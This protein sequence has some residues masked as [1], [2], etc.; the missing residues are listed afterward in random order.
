MWLEALYF[1]LF[2]KILYKYCVA[3]YAVVLVCALS[4]DQPIIQSFLVGELS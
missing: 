4:H 3:I 1:L 2:F